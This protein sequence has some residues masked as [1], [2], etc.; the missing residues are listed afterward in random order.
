MQP[1][2]ALAT[3]DKKSATADGIKEKLEQIFAG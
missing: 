1:F 2:E 3:R